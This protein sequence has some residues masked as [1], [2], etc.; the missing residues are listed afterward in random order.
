MIVKRN[1]LTALL[2]VAIAFGLWLYVVTVISPNSDN[3]YN[4]VSVVLQGEAILEERGLMITMDEIPTLSLR[5]EGN[6][7]EL[8]KLNSS[9]ISLTVDVSK[10]AE[11]GEHKLAINPS[12]IRLPGDVSYS[13]ITVASRK[14]DYITLV[15]KQRVTKTVPVDVDFGDSRVLDGYIA[16]T[17]NIALDY[18]EIQVSGPS[19]VVDQIAMA[20]IHVDLNDKSAT[21]SESQSFT[22]CNADEEPVDAKLITTNVGSVEFTLRILKVKEVA[23]KLNV[24]AGGGA[25]LED[26]DVKMD[27]NSILVSGTEAALQNLDAITVGTVNLGDLPQDTI[28]TF[29]I[30]LPDGVGNETGISNV[31]VGVVFNNLDTKTM[32]ITN[33]VAVNV[34]EEREP[35]IITKALEIRFRGP[36]ALIET[37]Q[38][39]HVTVAVDFSDAQVGTATLRAVVTF[40]EEYAQ[41]GAI[42]SYS[43]AATLK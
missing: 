30:T 18:S 16:D 19:D 28:L 38:P 34:P 22:L 43:V 31:L 3:T 25:T 9:N 39:E 8:Q 15:V 6:R 24:V 21:F 13:A 37:L 41:I 35:E 26:A 20:K 7:S 36:A 4:G 40:S 11:P 17:E 2:S 1:V 33:I 32:S 5:L 14:P 12:N 10:I 42:G 29:P 27:V 23:L